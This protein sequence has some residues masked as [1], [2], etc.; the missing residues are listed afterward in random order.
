MIIVMQVYH[1]QV[2]YGSA[3]YIILI[4]ATI[5]GNWYKYCAQWLRRVEEECCVDHVIRVVPSL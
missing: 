3:P 5:Q 2:V 1:V 4:Q